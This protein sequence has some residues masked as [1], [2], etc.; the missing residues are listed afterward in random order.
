MK[1]QGGCHCG[2][3]TFE[4]EGDIESVVGCNCSICT[5]RGYL[6]WFTPRDQVVLKNPSADMSTYTFNKQVIKHQFCPQCGCAPFG[7]GVDQNGNESAAINV[8]CLDNFDLSQ[9]TV[10]HYDGRSA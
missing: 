4:V 2:N 1:Y 5:K 8:R 6:L 7:F 10:H 9:I 3:I